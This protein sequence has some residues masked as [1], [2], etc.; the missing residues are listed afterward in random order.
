VWGLN[1]ECCERFVQGVY[2]CQLWSFTLA[3]DLKH[4]K[5]PKSMCLRGNDNS[6]SGR[7]RHGWFLM[8]SLTD[9]CRR[10]GELSHR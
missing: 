7:M 2:N 3:C 9:K 5:Q 6:R 4:P 8:C 10:Y 1:T